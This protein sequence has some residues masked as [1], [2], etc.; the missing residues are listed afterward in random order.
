MENKKLSQQELQQIETVKQKSQAVVQELGQIELLRLDLK[1]RKDD[2]LAFL[3]QLRQEEKELAQALETT[4]GKGMID[5]E[6]EEFI[7]YVEQAEVI[8]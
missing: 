3:E 6:K 8:G 1:S 7:P 2:A 5:L 4:Y